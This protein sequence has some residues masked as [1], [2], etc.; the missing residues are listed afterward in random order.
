MRTR[1]L[2]VSLFTLCLVTPSLSRAQETTG[3]IVG[4]ATDQTDGVLPGVA[5]VARHQQTGL[6]KEATTAEDGGFAISYLPIGTYDVTFTLSGF[7]THSARAV[8]LHVNDRVQVD[9]SL[10]VG[11]LAEVVEVVGATSLIQT[12]SAVQNLMGATQVGELP[13]NN[14]NFVQLA[15]LVPGVSSS[16]PDEVGIGLA[17]TVS[18]SI[19]GNR[20]NSVNWLVDGASIVD[21]GSNVTLLAT[22]TLD[23]SRS[24]RS[25]PA[26]TTPNGHAAAAASS[27][28]SPSR[29]AMCFAAAATST[30]GTTSS[31]RIVF[32]GSRARR[33]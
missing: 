25:S 2:L 8:E 11:E 16:L 32:S 19:G 5:V 29:A 18:L 4:K 30:I 6:T 23:S 13:L 1:Y 17:S 33:R 24:S 14:R 20:R 22:P 27:T 12:T 21:T 26:A 7:K 10:A 15:T 3:T 9:G 31:T 28:S